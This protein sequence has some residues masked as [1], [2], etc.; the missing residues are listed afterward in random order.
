[1]KFYISLIYKELR[2][3][4]YYGRQS[5]VKQVMLMIEKK[6]IDFTQ[7]NMNIIAMK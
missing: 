5:C 7:H 6:I 4:F 1:M 2:K 3:L